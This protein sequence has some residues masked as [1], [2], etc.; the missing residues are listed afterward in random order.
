MRILLSSR[1]TTANARRGDGRLEFDMDNDVHVRL[2]CVVS[3]AHKVVKGI[4]VPMD[5]QYPPKMSIWPLGSTTEACPY[6]SGGPLVE[7]RRVN[8][9]A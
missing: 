8:D 5:E 4:S 2:D 3:I 9:G 6:K 7:G 1:S